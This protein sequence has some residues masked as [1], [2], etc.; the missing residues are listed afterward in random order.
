MSITVGDMLDL[1]ARLK[2]TAAVNIAARTFVNMDGSLPASAAVCTGGVADID[3]PSGQ[4]INVKMPPGIYAVKATGTVTI[5]LMVELLQGTIYGNISGT[6][7]AITA[8]GVSV[9][10]SGYPMGRAYSAGSAGDTVLVCVSTSQ[11]K[12]V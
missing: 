9:I 10:A 1:G 2:V 7:T 5:G 8:S 6:K 3:T 4:S 11:V 12:I